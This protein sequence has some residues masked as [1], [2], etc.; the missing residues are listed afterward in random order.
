MKKIY[1]YVI[2]LWSIFFV[3]SGFAQCTFSELAKDFSRNTALKDFV[4]TDAKAFDAWY[5]LNKEKPSL[6]N[7]LPEVKIVAENFQEVKNAG[8]YQ[9]WIDKLST[10]EKN[11]PIL[12]LDSQQKFEQTVDVSNLPKHLRSLAYQYYKKANNENKL[13]LWQRLEEIFKEYK[14]NGNWPP[15]NGGYNIES[16]IS[17]QKFQKYDRYANPIGSWDGINEPLLGGNFTSPI[18]D[19]KPFDF[20]SRALNIPESNYTFY[21]EIEI[22]EDLGFDGELADVIP[23]F[24]QKGQGKQVKWNI[25]KDPTTGRP[26]TWNK[27]AEEGKVRITIK[28]IPNGNPD[29]I[30]KW[31][32]YVI[33]KKVNN[34]GNEIKLLG[35]SK[36]TNISGLTA[37]ENSIVYTEGNKII[38]DVAGMFKND[39]PGAGSVLVKDS[40]FTSA[41]SNKT[42]LPEGQ[43]P[44]GLHPLVKEWFQNPNI[45]AEELTKRLTHGKCAEPDAVSKW[46]YDYEQKT[47]IAIQ[48]MTDAR[49]AL[50]GTKSIAFETTTKYVKSDGRKII[51]AEI[52]DVKIACTS[53]NPFL[54]YFGIEE[55]KVNINIKFE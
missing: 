24:N 6:R 33:G 20:S 1:F 4:K 7:S 46:L 30:K 42:G 16:G 12:F 25:P 28:D 45:N 40:K 34:A 37:T 36:I 15:Y 14:I 13:H 35:S 18:I 52:G 19:N 32:G 50:K 11:V 53:C 26:K 49:N 54:E 43:L 48:N 17:L 23:W 44:E 21:Y 29:L 39:R 51:S 47:K 10:E 41:V 22:L 31:K 2:A 27:L 5:L 8:G 38:E 3:T 9:K 55:I